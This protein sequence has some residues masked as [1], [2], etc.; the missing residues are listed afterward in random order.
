MSLNDQ[1]MYYVSQFDKELSRFPW[2]IELERKTKVP[3]TYLFGGA[4]GVLAILIFFNVWGNLLTNLIGFV[5]PAYASFK[6]IESSNK[7]DDVQ[8]LTYWVVF[9]LLNVLE[10]FTDIL[11]FWIPF[12]YTCKT[13]LILYLLL[14]QFQGAAFLYQKFIRPT[15]LKGQGNIDSSFSKIKAKAQQAANDSLNG[16][17]E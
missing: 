9:G 16:K 6:A 2:A 5:Y 10:F 11:L 14:P 15:L 7:E 17:S 8:W 3:K 1:V 12:Y 13:A 4:G